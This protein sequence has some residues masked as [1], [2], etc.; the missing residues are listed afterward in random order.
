MKIVHLCLSNF[1]IDN[2][3]YQENII[4]K[5]HVKQ[6][7]EVTVIASLFSFN[8][9]GRGYY[10]KEPSE[11]INNDGVKVIR[12]AY[13]KPFV[14]LNRLKRHYEGFMEKLEQEKPDII[15]AHNFSMVDTKVLKLYLEKNPQVKLYADSHADYINSGKNFLSRKILHPIIWRHYSKLI[16]PFMIRCYGVT[17]Q[18]CRF[19]KE[20]Y[21]I[22]PEK[23]EY[24]P[25]GVDDEA[26]PKDR[27]SIR[28]SVRAELNISNNDILIFTGGKIDKLK[29]IHI[30]I[31]VLDRLK[32]NNLHL[33]IC[34]VFT[35]E[36]T[37]LE[38]II[39]T[40]HNN[41]HYLGWCTATRVMECMVA[42]DIACFP[43]THSTLWEQSVGIG[44]PAIFKR[45]DEMEQVNINGN[46]IFINGED[47][48]E[49]AKTIIFLQSPNN[50]DEYQ[51]KAVK[52]SK[53]FLYSNISKR[54]INLISSY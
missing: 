14:K 41:I 28:N 30:L 15:F 20:M 18:R 27:Q 26:I 23:I 44:M 21:H 46:C 1:F 51:K 13:K 47:Y 39:K 25:L 10:M 52:A 24:L 4:T 8:K 17:P 6:G 33:V 37:Y 54:A 2:F 5:Y 11:Y 12:I 29:N 32:M 48:D 50:F 16:E 35:P 49:L 36:M 31:E 9:N 3:S 34:G 19:L 43:G 45:W 7:H 22:T 53:F 42:A 38:D 40:N